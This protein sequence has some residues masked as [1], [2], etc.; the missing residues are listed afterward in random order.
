[1]FSKK[2]SNPQSI[3]SHSAS[4][5]SLIEILVVATIM[6]VLSS[7]GLV[8]FQAASQRA[9]NG[10]R[11]A[12]IAQV[13]S[14]LEIYRSTY[15]AYPTAS[16]FS[17]LLSTANFA[18]YLSQPDVSDPKNTSPFVY[19]YTSNGVTYSVCYTLEPSPG[20]TECFASP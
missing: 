14:A 2:Y 8:S 3:I 18:Q 11:E 1:M 20:E 6:I 9:R 7:I 10:R 12:D 13:R 19:T 15:S 4:G 17:E 5:F 16:S